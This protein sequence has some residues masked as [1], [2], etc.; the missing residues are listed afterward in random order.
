MFLKIYSICY[1]YTGVTFRRREQFAVGTGCGTEHRKP[2]GC[3]PYYAMYLRHTHS[4]IDQQIRCE[5][6]KLNVKIHAA[7]THL[8]AE[9][10]F[11]SLRKVRQRDVVCGQNSHADEQGEE[12]Q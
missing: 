11:V 2:S 1:H 3:H 8:S 6:W 9:E 7:F 5:R 4:D 10:S 12:V